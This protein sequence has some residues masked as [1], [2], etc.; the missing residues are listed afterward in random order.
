[1]TLIDE[2]AA[3]SRRA[4][5]HIVLPEGDD[6]RIIEAAR[7]AA[8]DG[9]ARLT[10]LGHDAEASDGVNIVDPAASADLPR[11]IDT[12]YELRKHKAISREAA[13]AAMT[14]PLGFAAMAVRLGDADA[15]IGGAIASPA[16]WPGRDAL[17]KRP[18][19]CNGLAAGFPLR[20]Q[21]PPRLQSLL[22]SGSCPCTA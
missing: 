8:K 4:S 20:D 16:A 15:T 22:S 6:P 17:C 2:I 5:P 10:L 12:Y 14:T 3:A 1:M 7:R 11:Y 13:V 18:S 9:L 19:L 21:P